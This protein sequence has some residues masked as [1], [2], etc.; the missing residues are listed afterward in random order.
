[1]QFHLSLCSQVLTLLTHNNKDFR[2]AVSK[3]LSDGWREHHLSL[4]LSCF[5][6]F[7]NQR[8]ESKLKLAIQCSVSPRKYFQEASAA[9]ANS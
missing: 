5:I 6:R 3:L 9:L 7:L 8:V 4:S 2:A 1:M